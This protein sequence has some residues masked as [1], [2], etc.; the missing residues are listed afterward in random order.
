M[1][2][3]LILKTMYYRHINELIFDSC[4]FE[5]EGLLRKLESLSQY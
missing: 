2:Q 1:F 3:F 5:V 4:I